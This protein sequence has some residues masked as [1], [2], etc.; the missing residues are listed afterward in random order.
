MAPLVFLN[1][2]FIA[3]ADGIDNVL[4]NASFII[5]LAGLIISI[6]FRKKMASSKT[7]E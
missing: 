7:E 5:S 3:W 1:L 2:V 6:I 4:L